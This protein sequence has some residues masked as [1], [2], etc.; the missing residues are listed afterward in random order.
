MLGT[1]S[2]N[3]GHNAG[4]NITPSRPALVQPVLTYDL[5]QFVK[6]V[7]RQKNASSLS[8]LG[9]NVVYSLKKMIENPRP[10]KQKPAI[11]H[12][13]DT[14]AQANHVRIRMTRQWRGHC[15]LMA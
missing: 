8:E 4:R 5:V 13:N 2:H 7:S 15:L 1:T 11:F 12:N 6:N 9:K 3:A 14:L 10:K